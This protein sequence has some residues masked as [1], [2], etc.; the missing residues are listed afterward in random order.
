MRSRRSPG[1][2]DPGPG[3]GGAL[4]SEGGPNGANARAGGHSAGP[5]GLS[6]LTLGF[7]RRPSLPGLGS[8]PATVACMTQ[9]IFATASTV[10]RLLVV[11]IFG[12]R[13]ASVCGR[14]TGPGSL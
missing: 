8:L 12:C 7:L 1:S 11:Y 14:T 3:L 10:T 2:A 4:R 5:S 13:T 9:G 6:Q